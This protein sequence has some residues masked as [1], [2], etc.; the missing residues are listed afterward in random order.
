VPHAR[1]SYLFPSVL[2]AFI[3]IRPV[4]A[5]ET[6]PAPIISPELNS[7]RSV[8]FRFRD[9]GAKAVLLSREGT[10]SVPMQKDDQG[11]WSVKTDPLEPDLYGYSFV[12]D[13]VTLIDPSNSAIKPNLLNLQSVVH[14]PGG[15]PLPWEMTSVPHGEIH[16]HFYKSAIVGDDR[17]YYVYTPPNYDPK[18]STT[19]PVLYLL[20]GYSDD[21]S[22]WTAV[23]KANLILDNLL[24]QGKVKPM[25][26]VMP[27][28]YGAPEIVSKTGPAFRDA[29]LRDRNFSRFREAL[30]NEVLPAVERDYRVSANRDSRAIAGL[31]MGGAETL[32]TGL[33]ATDKFAYVGA[34]SSGG[35]GED[36]APAFPSLDA[37]VNS[38]V[39]TL[40]ISCGREDR[41]LGFNQ[42]FVAFLNSKGIQCSL[43][44]TGGAHTWMVWRRNLIDFTPLLFQ[45]SAAH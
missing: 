43:H 40:W 41:L 30:L 39:K 31:S 27:L 21:A 20:H 24:A 32:Y 11:V 26:I 17:D 35:L 34:F 29:A 22:G 1:L 18:G 15:T 45:N 42:K 5:Q 4:P 6:K 23:G 10:T 12:A 36:F 8:T 14:V 44:E 3:A 2:L 19:Y 9:P 7:D 38:K 37:S 13:G 16:H 28:G 25:I 33:N